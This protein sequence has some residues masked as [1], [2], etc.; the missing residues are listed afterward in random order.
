M[1][2]DRLYRHDHPDDPEPVR[3]GDL[4]EVAIKLTDHF[5]NILQ[6]MGILGL[7]LLLILVGLGALMLAKQNSNTFRAQL[8]VCAVA[9]YADTQAENIHQRA[10]QS[11]PDMRANLERSATELHVLAVRMRDTGIHCPP[12]GG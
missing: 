5:R 11:P 7:L 1:S 6:W 3:W 9:G 8:A 12:G 2:P 4:R 10:F